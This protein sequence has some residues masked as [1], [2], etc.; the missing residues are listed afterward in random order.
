MGNGARVLVAAALLA[1]AVAL[2]AAI[3]GGDRGGDVRGAPAPSSGSGAGLGEPLPKGVATV[4]TAPAIAVAPEVGAPADA[5]REARI[6]AHRPGAPPLRWIDLTRTAPASRGDGLWFALLADPVEWEQLFRSMH[7][8]EA[9]WVDPLEGPTPAPGFDPEHELI[10]VVGLGLR[11][12]IDYSIHLEPVAPR[13]PE[14]RYRLRV[15]TPPGFVTEVPTRPA[16]AYRIPRSVVGDRG[17]VVENELGLELAI[18]A[19]PPVPEGFVP[20]GMDADR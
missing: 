20:L 2:T 17:L 8:A 3:L 19:P 9:R 15:E 1:A 4:D 16:Q 18:L 10:L 5:E 14:A 12:R 13:A 6:A 11:P 7:E